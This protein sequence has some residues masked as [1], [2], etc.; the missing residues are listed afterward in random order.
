MLSLFEP[1]KDRGTREGAVRGLSSLGDQGIK[2]GL[3]E[4][5]GAKM[6]DEEYGEGDE[7]IVGAVLVS[8][9]L[10]AL[11]FHRLLGHMFMTCVQEQLEVLER[12]SE[13]P[14]PLDDME[15]DV[16]DQLVEVFGETFAAKIT[17]DGGWARRLLAKAQVAG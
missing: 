10:T 5:R 4:S 9:A 7:G 1:G 15:S 8:L 2:K 6:L 17:R 16:R 12:R 3:I 13:N 14:V 11:Q